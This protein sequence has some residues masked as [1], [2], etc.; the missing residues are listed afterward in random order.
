MA[1]RQEILQCGFG[2]QGQAKIKEAKAK[3]YNLICTIGEVEARD[4]TL[5]VD[6]SRWNAPTFKGAAKSVGE[7]DGEGSRRWVLGLDR[8]ES[9]MDWMTRR[10]Y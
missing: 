8:L 5:S 2:C 4:K 1:P 6:P 7:H 9:M 10:Y 3:R